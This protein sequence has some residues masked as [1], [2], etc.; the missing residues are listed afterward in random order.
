VGYAIGVVSQKPALEH[1]SA[2]QVTTC[3]CAVGAVA[4]LPFAGQ[5]VDDVRTAPAGAVVAMVYLGLLPTAVAF[6][7]WAYALNRTT[8]GKL[9]A[10]T[11]LVPVLVVLMA[12]IVRRE[13][14]GPWALA[15][16]A[17]CLAGVALSRRR[18]SKPDTAPARPVTGARS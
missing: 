14:P 8:A 17:L 2:L 1:A 7:T 18:R 11:Y 12:W 10:T 4:C 6:W 5:L 9:G 15:G 13:A 3:A 16:G